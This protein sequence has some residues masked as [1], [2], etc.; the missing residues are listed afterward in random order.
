MSHTNQEKKMQT[1]EM[2]PDRY[3]EGLESSDIRVTGGRR[4][5]STSLHFHAD[6]IAEHGFTALTGRLDPWVLF[7]CQH[8]TVIDNHGGSAATRAAMEIELALGEPF[9]MTGVEGT[10]ALVERNQRLLEGDGYK[11]V[12]YQDVTQVEVTA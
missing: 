3:N 2:R 9:Q 7:A 4:P 10:W 8:C 5:G 12:P 1:I 11:P 6:N